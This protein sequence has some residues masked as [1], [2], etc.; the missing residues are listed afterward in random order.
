MHPPQMTYVNKTTYISLETL[1]V[2]SRV[3]TQY[4][5]P[6]RVPLTHLP[7]DD[8]D[9]SDSETDEAPR[10][11]GR[12]QG[13][14]R[15]RASS[16][17]ASRAKRC[18]RTPAAGRGGDAAR[19][20]A[21]CGQPNDSSEEEEEED[22]EEEDEEEE[23]EE[24][25]AEEEG[26][27]EKGDDGEDEH[28]GAD[29]IGDSSD[30]DVAATSRHTQGFMPE[31]A[32]VLMPPEASFVPKACA[33]GFINLAG[34]PDYRSQTH[35]AGLVYVSEIDISKTVAKVWWFEKTW[36]GPVWTVAYAVYTK[37]WNDRNWGKAYRK[38]KATP[39]VA[40]Y[41]KHWH[42]QDTPFNNF[43][44]IQIDPDKVTLVPA[45]EDVWTCEKVK[46]T[47]AYIDAVMAP[48]F[49]EYGCV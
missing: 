31:P 24:E 43:V 17:G 7:A 9:D 45:A 15:Q 4:E 2:L 34:T 33:F 18:R 8:S 35:L 38:K 32:R 26:H 10:A 39:P 44:P 20:R 29:G 16:A 13:A 47:A 5:M 37:Y 48:A 28:S 30:E 3:S 12:A 21:R 49:A 22:E 19:S 14:G 36:T 6:A 46:F 41:R 23:E 27:K 1:R 25:D 42:S 40:E 11:T